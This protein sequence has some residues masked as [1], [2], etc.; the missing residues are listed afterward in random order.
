MRTTSSIP[1]SFLDELINKSDIFDVVSGYVRLTKRTGSNVFGLCPFHGEKT[2]SFSVN[3][4]KQIFY[5]FGCQKG[6]GVINFIREIENVPFRDA[7]EI[8]AKRAGMTVPSSDADNEIAEKRRRMFQLNRDAARHFHELLSS[9]LA[10][11]ARDYLAKRGISK[12]MVTRF[13][14]GAAPESW[15]LLVDS[16]IK[17]GYTLEELIEA[18]LAKPRQKKNNEIENSAYD[19]FRNRLIFPVID[20]RG[21]VIGFSGRI[22]DD[23]EPKYLNS[24]E[25]LV[26]NKRRSLF[27]LNIAK[28]TKSDTFILV[29]GNID[30]VALHQAGFDN[31]VASL[32]TAL[33]TE[34]AHLISR[35]IN[36][37]AIAY[38]SDESG[39]NAVLRTIPILEKAGLGVKVIDLGACGDP[40]DYIKKH[41]AD[42]FGLLLERGDDH[43]DYQLLTIKNNHN[44]TTDSGRLSYVASATDL[45]VTLTSDLERELYGAKVA[46]IV[47]VSPEAIKTEI[48]RKSK[49][50][51]NQKKKAFERRVSRPTITNQ[52][53]T[54]SLRY[55]NQYSAAAEEGVIRSLIQDPTLIKITSEMKFSET[56]FTSEFLS[57]IY[58]M[59]IYRI[60]TDKLTD[61]S[62]LMA[63]LERDES[64]QLTSIIQKPETAQSR[65]NT[66]REYIDKIRTENLRVR[67][68]DELTLLE[69]FEKKRLLREE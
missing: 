49:K 37:V 45:L 20:T 62:Q 40:D 25:T 60:E 16:M 39:K 18:G 54:R 35:H 6:G 66:I 48:K 67:Q 69:M 7:V 19:V 43:I 47:G 17:R 31:T 8:L 22:I 56:E 42:A 59:L 52:P 15:N 68:P 9:P 64:S 30:V 32:G 13:G 41:G 14:I 12:A 21:N 24:R 27:A 50:K 33:T 29:E 51:D 44:L 26:Y 65:E 5:C 61:A 3:T 28:K 23:G 55:N 36:K 58:K 1:D 63:E 11:S 46:N 38:D 57:K 34:Q 53:E 4:D 2:P 10:Q